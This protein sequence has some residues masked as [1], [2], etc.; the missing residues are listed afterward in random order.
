MRTYLQARR[1]RRVER[2]RVAAAWSACTA[3]VDSLDLTGQVSVEDLRAAV[4]RHQQRTI[5]LTPFALES[6][7]VHGLLLSTDDVDYIVF[8]QN[9]MPF[10]Q[11]HI[12][13][14]ELGHIMLAHASSTA[15]G[16]MVVSSQ[17]YALSTAGLPGEGTATRILGRHTY[18]DRQELEAE[19][20]ASILGQRLTAHRHRS[21][22]CPTVRPD[23]RVV[24]ILETF[25]ATA[26]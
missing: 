14:H 22:P 9:T 7:A 4:A 12:I 11:E 2:D 18:E 6:A 20:M 3:A 5:C 23:P 8:E 19:V 1:R 13:L 26:N 17:P 25:A 21:A 24:R 16:E 10:H 15:V